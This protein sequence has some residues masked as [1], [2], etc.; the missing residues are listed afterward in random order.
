MVIAIRIA[1]AS[2]VVVAACV[3]VAGIERALPFDQGVGGT[4]VTTTAS[5]DG[6]CG[7]GCDDG[8]DCTVDSC[9]GTC[10]HEPSPKDAPC[11]D[12]GG[13]RCDGEG[14]CVECTLDA[15]CQKPQ[16]CGAVKAHHCGCAPIPCATLGLTCGFEADDGCG[17][18]LNC[19]D[20]KQNGGET[21]VD[22]GGPDRACSIRC[23]ADKKCLED[24]DCAE[25][26][27]D[28]L[29]KRCTKA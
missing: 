12:D 15:H 23:N 11:Q 5:G 20:L 27:C 16:T 17:D 1:A 4:A 29:T 24:T 21:D 28:A 10:R 14:S 9:E 3:Q 7:G 6:G 18:T 26:N 25:M 13:E 19:N 22:C 8:N 2:A